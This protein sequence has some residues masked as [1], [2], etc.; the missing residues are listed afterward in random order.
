MINTPTVPMSIIVLVAFAA[1]FFGGF[2]LGVYY[3][4]R[5]EKLKAAKT[6]A[7][8]MSLTWISFHVYSLLT[9]GERVATVFDV[10]GALAVGNVIGFDVEVLLEKVIGRKK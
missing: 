8:L 5:N 7:W 10:V 4:K 1:G 2:V 3:A 6:L 9:T